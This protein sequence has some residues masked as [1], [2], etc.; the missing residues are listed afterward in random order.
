[1]VC[2]LLFFINLQKVQEDG[3]DARIDKVGEHRS[4]NGNNEKRFYSIAVFITYSTHVGHSI[5][6]STK[7]KATDAC[8]QDGSIIVAPQNRGHT[9]MM[10]NERARS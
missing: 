7:T 10:I 5:G 2:T 9:K 4:D 6:C 8:T 1:M 3:N